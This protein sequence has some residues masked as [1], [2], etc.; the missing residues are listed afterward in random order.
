[1]VRAVMLMMWPL[2]AAASSLRALSTSVPFYAYP[3]PLLVRLTFRRTR[4]LAV[5]RL[6]GFVFFSRGVRRTALGVCVA[7]RQRL[8]SRARGSLYT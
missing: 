5:G 6:L 2:A 8:G 1:M 3:P 4:P 7:A